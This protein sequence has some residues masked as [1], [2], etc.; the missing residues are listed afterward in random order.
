LPIPVAVY[1]FVPIYWRF[2]AILDSQRSTSW[3]VR[4]IRRLQTKSSLHA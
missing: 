2:S 1:D 3:Y 4:E